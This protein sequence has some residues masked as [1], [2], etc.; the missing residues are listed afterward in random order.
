MQDRDTKIPGSQVPGEPMTAFYCEKHD[1]GV[2]VLGQHD[3]VKHVEWKAT[4]CTDDMCTLIHHHYINA[5]G[6]NSLYSQAI[7]DLYYGGGWQVSYYGMANV[8][9]IHG[10]LV[11]EPFDNIR[12]PATEVC[13]AL[14]ELELPALI[15]LGILDER[16]PNVIRMW[17]KWEMITAV[18]HFHQRRASR[19]SLK[20]DDNQ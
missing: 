1:Q 6:T 20:T 14:H 18:K 8:Y 16:F 13:I 19:A 3:P 10:N 15:T 4:T 5:D 11:W 12:E 2:L 7:Y 9:D 17:P